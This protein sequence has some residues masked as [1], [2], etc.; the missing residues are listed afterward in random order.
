MVKVSEFIN[1]IMAKLIILLDGKLLREY[2]IIKERVMIGR[3]PSNDIHIDNLAISGEHALIL[4]VGEDALLEDLNSTNG[5][6]VNKKLVKKQLLQ[7]NDIIELGKY[8]LKFIADNTAKKVVKSDGFAQTIMIKPE[9][10]AADAVS[11]IPA[12]QPNQQALPELSQTINKRI[13]KLITADSE[14]AKA[15][16]ATATASHLA[17]KVN[18]VL[19]GRLQILSGPHAGQTILLDKAMTKLGKV[20]DQIALVTKRPQGFFLT[21]IGGDQRPIVNGNTI[22]VQ[23]FALKDHDQIEISDEKMEFHLD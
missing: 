23:A 1:K 14:Q 10:D 6:L 5:T 11:A 12:D 18:V 16:A 15:A 8:Q 7:H 4:T 21:H 20:G 3:R 17:T 19:V 13:A 22:G 2:V 9:Q